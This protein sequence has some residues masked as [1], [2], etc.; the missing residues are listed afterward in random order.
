[1]QLVFQVELV[2]ELEML[3]EILMQLVVLQVELETPVN[4]LELLLEKLVYELE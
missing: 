3:Q 2:Y 1:M 4:E